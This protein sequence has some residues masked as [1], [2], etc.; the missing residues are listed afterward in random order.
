MCARLGYDT[1]SVPALP[2]SMEIDG[3]TEK[4]FMQGLTRAPAV[5]EGREHKQIPLLA[6]KR[7]V[8]WFLIWAQGWDVSRGGAKRVA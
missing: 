8:S 6:P 2:Q 5:A 1:A 4:Q 3:R 7:K